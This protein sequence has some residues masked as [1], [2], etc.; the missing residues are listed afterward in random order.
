[1]SEEEAERFRDSSGHSPIGDRRSY[2][3]R[4]GVSKQ[5]YDAIPIDRWYQR[6]EG[7]VL[8][9]VELAEVRNETQ[10]R[11]SHDQATY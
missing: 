6:H 10:T 5:N 8:L 2:F 7:G 1:M 9:P 11:K 3:V 4:F